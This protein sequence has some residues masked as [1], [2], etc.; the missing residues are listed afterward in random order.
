MK[1]PFLSPASLKTFLFKMDTNLMGA[2]VDGDVE[3]AMIAL[4]SGANPNYTNNHGMRPLHICCGGTGPLEML[5]LLLAA[6]AEIDAADN[7]GWTA[8]HYASSSGQAPLVERLLRA[9]AQINAV[10]TDR[11]WT[12]LTR[13]AYRACPHI[14]ELLLAAGADPTQQTEVSV[15]RDS[16]SK[17]VVRHLTPHS[18]GKTALEWAQCGGHPEVIEAFHRVKSTTGA[19]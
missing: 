2:A 6:G 9:S 8:L 12:P 14:I 1:I 4:A 5:E 11:G 7:T 18:Q 19:A 17:V 10:T 15:T 16:Y 13:A 3:A